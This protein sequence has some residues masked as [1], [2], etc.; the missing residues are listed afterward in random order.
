MLWVQIPLFALFYILSKNMSLITILNFLPF[1]ST[2][3]L[4]FLKNEKVIKNFSIFSSFFIFF[5][6]LLLW[7]F[8][9]TGASSF[10][11]YI[12]FNKLFDLNENLFY[13]FQY[14]F[15]G[16]D[17]ISLFFIIITTFLIPLSILT[18]YNV[19]TKNI[20]EYYILFFLLEFGVLISFTTLDL[21]IFYIFFESVLIPMFL[22]IGVWGSRSRKIKASYYFFIYTLFGSLFMLIAIIHIYL[23]TGTS[24]YLFLY[25]YTF[26]FFLEK[27]YFLAF[28]IAFAFKIP[29]IPFHIWLPEAHVE[30]PTA[31]SVILA[32]ILLKLG[33]YGLIRFTLSL[34]PKASL[35][36]SPIIFVFCVIS[37]IYASLT[38]IRQTDLKKI[39]AYASVAHMNMIVLGIFSLTMQGLQGGLFQAISHSIVSSALFLSIGMIYDRYHTRHIHYY[40]GLAHFMPLYSLFLVFYIFANIAIPCTSSFVGELLILIGIFQE[41][42]IIGFLAAFGS[43]VLGTCYS[44]LLVNH[45][46]FGNINF[47]LKIF[48]DLTYREIFIHLILIIIILVMGLYPK[49]FYLF[50]DKSILKLIVH[51]EFNNHLYYIK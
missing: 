3:I 34:F 29:M 4:F 40:G 1:L 7:I 24:H 5:F 12:F 8:F 2:I 11:N 15:F 33:S 18:S 21:I 10:Q 51:L 37:I 50:M 19:I 9:D 25:N 28:F 14:H 16:I 35:F 38:A 6:S 32:G 27:I 41:N 39:I 48:Y 36:F 43:M 42:T 49:I 44:I 26:D 31:G 17:G 22:I 20:K 46:C 13:Y 47:H 45:I 23:I 30:A